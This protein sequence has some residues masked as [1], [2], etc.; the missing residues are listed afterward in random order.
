MP[1]AATPEDG[2]GPTPREAIEAIRAE[3]LTG[4]QL[5]MARRIAQKHGLEPQSDLDAVRMLRARG[6]DPFQSANMLELVVSDKAAAEQARLPST[7]R[8]PQPPAAP[9]QPVPPGAYTGSDSRMRDIMNIQRDLVR[10]R[11]RKLALLAVRLAFFVGLPTLIA[12]YYYYNIATPM[13][14]TKSEF[15]IQQ[16]EP[17]TGQLAGMFSGTT[18]ATTQDSI[19]VQSY[20]Q[21]RDAMMRLD[22]E[23]GF[24][25]H[26]ADPRID[27]I[28]RLASDSNEAAYKIY[29][30]HVR[31]GYDPT[32]GIIKME[33]IAADPQ[34]SAKFSEALADYAEEQVDNLTHRLREDQMQGARES[35]ADAEEKMLA[36][37]N[38][39]LELQQKRGVLSAELEVSSRMSQI[40]TF[41]L[42]LKNERLKLQEL[43]DNPSPNRTRVQVAE[44]NIA[45]L[46]ELIASMRAEMTEGTTSSAS[47]ARISGEL[48]VAETDLQT[49]QLMLSQALQ[50]LETA[51][52]EANRQVRYL[53]RPVNPVAPDDAT[54][55]RRFENTLLALLIFAG[56]YLMASLTASILREQVSS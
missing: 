23:L 39:V 36:A 52:I 45:R 3:N 6:V 7:V 11:R 47:L 5:R 25:E 41:E 29:K 28:Q 46:E 38:R 44:R 21:S 50:Q 26:F 42:E 15:L 22:R 51:R 10:R 18:F 43:M 9:Q 30:R 48:V 2:A 31:I 1:G 53:S 34:L 27:P 49:R 33:V 20:L 32:E 24:R 56:I 35:Y 19:A 40:S 16:A 4:R 13:Y 14:A 54:Y 55:P 17:A 8:Q 12:G 37:Q